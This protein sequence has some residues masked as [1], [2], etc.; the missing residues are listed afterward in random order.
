[1]SAHQKS[2]GCRCGGVRFDVHAPAMLTMA[3]HCK[4]CQR[5][6]GSAFSLSALY[7]A[8]AFEI[9]SGVPVK[10]G[11]KAANEHFVCPECSGW[12]FTRVATSTGAL[13]NVRATMFDTCDANPPFIETCAEEKL[14]W[15]DVKASHSFPQFPPSA[16]FGHL[17]T[18]FRGLPS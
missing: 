6:T 2:G 5:M 17:I 14:A 10:G 15:V 13:V 8:T 4:G 11:M 1:M 12:I 3:C 18:Q 16:E 7:A 9:I